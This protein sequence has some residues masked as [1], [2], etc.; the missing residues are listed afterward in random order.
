MIPPDFGPIF[1]VK[2]VRVG[3][4]HEQIEM[5][6]N[7]WVCEQKWKGKDK[8]HSFQNFLFYILRNK[9]ATCGLHICTDQSALGWWCAV[10]IGQRQHATDVAYFLYS[11]LYH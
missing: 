11:R 10:I 6:S 8:K 7:V 1:G 3:S 5:L 9:K 2:D 4:W